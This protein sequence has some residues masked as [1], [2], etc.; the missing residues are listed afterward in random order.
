MDNN[1]EN[2][3]TRG[4]PV[5]HKMD[6]K[7]LAAIPAGTTQMMQVFKIRHKETGIMLAVGVFVSKDAEGNLRYQLEQLVPKSLVD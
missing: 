7:D 3:S 5:S 6:P 1:D 4:I 2:E